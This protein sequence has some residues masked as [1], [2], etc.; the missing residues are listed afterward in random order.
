MRKL[1]TILFLFIWGSSFANNPF[2]TG[3]YIES[4]KL[5]RSQFW[6]TYYVRKTGN[7]GTGDGSIGNPWLTVLHAVTTVTSSGNLI[8]VG[9]G[10]FLETAQLVL[11]AGVS[12]VG[13]DSNSTI[14][15]STLTS[16]FQELLSIR[17]NTQNANGNLSISNVRFDGR[18][19]ATSWGI[20]IGGYGN[21][22]I[23]NCAFQNFDESGVI[24]SS[25]NDF[26]DQIEPTTYAEGSNVYNCSLI[27]CSKADAIYGRG[28]IRSI[29]QKDFTFHDNKITQYQRAP[30]SN[31][32][33]IKLINWNKNGE[34]YNNILVKGPY[35]YYTEGTNNRFAF[36]IE[37]G[38]GYG[39]NIH[40]NVSTSS[41]D[42]NRCYKNGYAYALWIHH[43][44]IGPDVL[45]TNQESGVW[46]EFDNSD[47]IIEYN[48][49]KNVTNAF[50]FSTRSSSLNERIYFQYNLCY[51]GGR[52]GGSG[53]AYVTSI[54]D[55]SDNYLLDSF[56]IIHNTFVSNASDPPAYWVSLSSAASITNVYIR[57]NIF[58]DNGATVGIVAGNATPINGLFN[59]YNMWY[60]NGNSNN[61]LW[62]AGSPTNYVVNNNLNT[63]P[64]LNSTGNLYTL[65]VGSPAINSASDGT[66]RGY[67]GGTTAPYV[68]STS[69]TNGATG[70]SIG[71][72]A[73]INFNEALDGATVN[74]TNCYIGG[75]TSSVSM[76]GNSIYINPTSDLA[77]NTAYTVTITTAVT[78]AA[79]NPLASNYTFTFTTQSSGT[80]TIRNYCC[81]Q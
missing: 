69:P 32:Y 13:V 23:F 76:V 37:I 61:A 75:V 8:D 79:G 3:H 81:P 49:F 4:I 22:D 43:N 19:L 31:G 47:C 70:I 11:S 46:L 67:T 20:A 55:G 14:I 73:V 35:Q 52:S 26:D 78:D 16:P 71:Q 38:D 44:T 59:T 63:N 28:A 18:N 54:T 40:D 15:Q 57:D 2:A 45:S 72:T 66:D 41:F 58:Q 12:I 74:S 64:D 17:T 9:A 36:A 21:V 50:L 27:N 51:G 80:T 6:A 1:F 34:I 7:D 25:R 60:N 77:Y 68:L 24:F 5:D 10:T 33:C 53:D 65:N 42:A 39:L 30:D 29:G 48:T 62:I 56:F